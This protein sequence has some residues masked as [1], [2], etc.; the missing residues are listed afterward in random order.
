ML[1]LAL[2]DVALD[3]SAAQIA[4]LLIVRR[5]VPLTTSVIIARHFDKR[6][7]NVLRDIVNL[8]CSDKFSRLNFEP[9]NYTDERGKTQPMYHIT[10]QGF[11]FLVMGFTGRKAAAWKER[12][13]NAF[14]AMHQVLE[15]QRN[16]AWQLQR[17]DGKQVRTDM[18]DSLQR[19][20]DYSRANGST[21]SDW[22]YANYTR[23]I[24]KALFESVDT[25]PG[26]FRDSLDRN[27]L[28]KLR[29]AEMMVSDLI[30]RSID[31]RVPYKE[32]YV[33]V[34]ER[35]TNYAAIVGRTAVLATSAVAQSH[36]AVSFSSN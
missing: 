30:D 27:Q 15:R 9:R 14:H 32:I 13:I 12:F 10:E 4:D 23:M 17:A 21:H 2:L 3:P 25:P 31:A 1:P 28:A 33:A 22:F 26:A 29:V 24:N 20:E 35:V 7:T 16:E 8:E 6:H 34:K 18:T 19:L 11:A 36:P 5:E